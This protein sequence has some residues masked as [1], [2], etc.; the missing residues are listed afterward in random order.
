MGK[1]FLSAPENPDKLYVV[2]K[3]L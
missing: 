2:E 3:P 1:G